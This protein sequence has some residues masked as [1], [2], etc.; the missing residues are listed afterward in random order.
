MTIRIS[1][2][3]TGEEPDQHV[4]RVAPQVSR[5]T[6]VREVPTESKSGLCSRDEVLAHNDRSTR[7]SS[8]CLILPP[9]NHLEVGRG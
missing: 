6:T 9:L 5:M 2:H 3:C 4:V 7:P 1:V 8:R